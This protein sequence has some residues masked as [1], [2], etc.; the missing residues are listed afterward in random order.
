MVSIV[1]T[2]GGKGKTGAGRIKRNRLLG[3]ER[4]RCKVA[5]YSTVNVVRVL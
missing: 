4:T 5:M 3:I 2:V 1:E